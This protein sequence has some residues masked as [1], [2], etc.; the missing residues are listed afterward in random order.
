MIFFHSESEESSS[1][2]YCYGR[3]SKEWSLPMQHLWI[4][5][6]I[7]DWNAGVMQAK[8]PRKTQSNWPSSDTGCSLLILSHL[9]LWEIKITVTV[10]LFNSKLWI[11]IFL[12]LAMDLIFNFFIS[13][14]SKVTQMFYHSHVWTTQLQHDLCKTKWLSNIDVTE[15]MERKDLHLAGRCNALNEKK[16]N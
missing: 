5:S 8:Y 11:R 1:W 12:Y 9:Y 6:F 13:I 15:H 10:F 3:R 16:K 14:N 7:Q 4:P 2:Y